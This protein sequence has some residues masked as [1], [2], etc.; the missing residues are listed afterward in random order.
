MPTMRRADER[1]P[2]RDFAIS[3]VPCQRQ[4]WHGANSAA[5]CRGRYFAHGKFRFEKPRAVHFLR[6]WR[7]QRGKTLLDV[8]K[9]SGFSE[10]YLSQVETGK[11]PRVNNDIIDGYAKALNVSRG[12]LLEH[13]PL[14]GTVIDFSDPALIGGIWEDIPLEDRPQAFRMLRS[15][16]RP[17]E[18]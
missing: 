18:K 9:V 15:L 10:S 2:C 12:A 4:T 8:A 14:T 13:A 16:S 7:K 11:R 5:D 6:A 3:Q 17:I 1:I